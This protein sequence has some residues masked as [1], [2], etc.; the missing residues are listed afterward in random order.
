[1]QIPV[2]LGAGCS[3]GR[4]KYE[5][6]AILVDADMRKKG[7]LEGACVKNAATIALSFIL[8]TVVFCGL[9]HVDAAPAPFSGDI[10][11]TPDGTV[12]GTDK[13]SREGNVYTL[14]A[15]LSGATENGQTYISIEKDDVILD[16]AGRTIR[17]AGTGVALAV[18]GR[19][20]VTIK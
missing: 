3:L 11:I 7:T 4:A 15:D 20:D 18:Y 9:G 16:G 17:G 5:F 13:I 1:M 8:L 14:L 19:R 6:W 12:E 10:R 2:L